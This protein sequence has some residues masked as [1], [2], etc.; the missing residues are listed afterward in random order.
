M[1]PRINP[2][3]NCFESAETILN[4]YSKFQVEKQTTSEKTIS[5]TE[6]VT[7]VNPRGKLTQSGTLR[8]GLTEASVNFQDEKTKGQMSSSFELACLM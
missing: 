7:I 3:E 2:T 1:T 8:N 4:N 5:S 6:S